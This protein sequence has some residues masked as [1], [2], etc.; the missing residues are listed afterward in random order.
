MIVRTLK[1]KKT[2]P[3]PLVP[4]IATLFPAGTEKVTPSRIFLSSK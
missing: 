4:T 2:L 1:Q 3:L